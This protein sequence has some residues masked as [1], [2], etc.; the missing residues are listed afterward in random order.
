MANKYNDTQN[1]ITKESIFTALM[2]LMEKKN[3][4][5]ISI[6]EVTQK[7]GVS[8]MAFY[9]NYDILE[10][11]ISVYLDEIFEEYS[12]HISNYTEAD[13]YEFTYS[14]FS[15]FRKHQKLITNLINS[16]LNTLILEKSVKFLH[17]LCSSIACKNHCSIESQKYN[18]AF[19]AGGF[20][21]V[22]M[23]WSKSGMK[24]SD[25]AMAKMVYERLIMN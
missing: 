16:D 2:I 20:Y 12:N 23:E 13:N 18:N 15:H 6:T 22:L 4:K 3:F 5:N 25:E 10:D 9:R 19:I 24:E 14:F 8:R 1:K 21:N 11:I 7:A 17:S